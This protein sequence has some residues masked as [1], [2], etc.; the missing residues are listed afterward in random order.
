MK[1]NHT[2]GEWIKGQSGASFNIKTEYGM[3][4]PIIYGAS[5]LE[6]EANALLISKAPIM[7]NLLITQ[8]KRL[9][10]LILLTP[11]GKERNLLTDENTDLMLLIDQ[12]TTI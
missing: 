4:I 11:S 12:L 2:Q 10:R 3:I 1:T 9:E 5:M 7:L 8:Q 6:S